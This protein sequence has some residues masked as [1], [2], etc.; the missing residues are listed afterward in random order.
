MLTITL[1]ASRFQATV[2]TTV[3]PCIRLAFRIRVC[4]GM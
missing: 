3:C 2:A 4:R 1:Q